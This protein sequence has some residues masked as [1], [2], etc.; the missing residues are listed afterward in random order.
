M[1]ETKQYLANLEK[2]LKLKYA[3][4]KEFIQAVQEFLDTVEPFLIKNPEFVEKNILE[5][6]L[7]PERVIEFRIPWMNDNGDWKVNIGYRVQ[8]NSA[9]GPYKGGMRLHPTVNQSIMK[10]LAFEQIFKNSLTSLPIGGGKGGSDFDPKGKS[11]GEI[12]RFCQSLMQELQKY[13]GPNE[14]VPAGDIGV[15][16]REI[17]YLFGEYKRLNGYHAGVLT[18]KPLSYWGSL[19]RTEATGY[20]LVYFVS[21]LLKDQ[22]DS[23]EGKKVL[24]SGSGNVAIYAIEKAQELGAMVYGCCDSS[25]SIIDPDGI[26][27]ALLKEIK[28]VKRARIN[29]YLEVRPNAVFY[30]NQSV[31]ELD[32]KYDIALPCATQNEI[33]E[34]LAEKLVENGVKIVAEGANMPTT[35]EALEIL[36]ENNVIYCPGKA[37]N[38]GGVAVSALEMAQNAQRLPWT[39]EKVD[40]ELNL[41]MKNIFETCRD[42]SNEYVGDFDLVAGANIAGFERVAKAMLSQGLV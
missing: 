11:D 37:A 26:D 33:P 4:Q 31:W 29:T 36:K 18:G 38:A 27:L 12:M 21:H 6:L 20:G 41:I 30:P 42:T 32:F 10:F 34:N 25:G 28:E 14:D 19:A 15:G 8:Y 17:G 39:F 40:A 7:I 5:M 16:A 23:L 9:L 1:T 3:E 2:D 13:I 35:L 22:N 24:V